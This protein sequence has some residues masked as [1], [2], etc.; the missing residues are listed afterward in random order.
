MPMLS[1]IEVRVLGSLIE[2]QI[3]DAGILSAD[4]Q[5]VDGRVQSKEQSQSHNVSD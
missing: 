3:H 1:P 5:F 2:K 4:P